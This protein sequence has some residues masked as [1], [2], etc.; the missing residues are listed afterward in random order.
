MSHENMIIF[1]DIIRKPIG[2]GQKRDRD[3]RR[4]GYLWVRFLGKTKVTEPCNGTG[5]HINS[6]PLSV[7]YFPV[8]VQIS[9]REFLVWVK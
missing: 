5:F 6:S 9:V 8:L 4:S 3:T 1:S 7:Q 2:P